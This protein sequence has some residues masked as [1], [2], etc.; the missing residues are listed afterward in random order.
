MVLCKTISILI[1]VEVKARFLFF[2]NKGVGQSVGFFD[3]LLARPSDWSVLHLAKPNATDSL[4]TP[5]HKRQFGQF[6]LVESVF[7]ISLVGIAFGKTDS[8]LLTL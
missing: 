1:N 5:T 3:I 4:F 2:I 6:Q 7:R 8:D